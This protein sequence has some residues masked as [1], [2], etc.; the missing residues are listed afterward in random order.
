[1]AI[2]H[3]CDDIHSDRP[4][5]QPTGDGYSSDVSFSIASTSPPFTWRAAQA[6]PTSFEAS[7]PE[8]QGT[9]SHL[10]LGTARQDAVPY[11]GELAGLETLSVKR[12]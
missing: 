6:P 12:A 7:R 8:P 4:D 10:K 9:R 2:E 1:M 5:Q 11:L 3:R